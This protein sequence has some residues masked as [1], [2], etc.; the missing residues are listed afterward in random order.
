MNELQAY[1]S[2]YRNQPFLLPNPE[3]FLSRI[4][5]IP[6]DANVNIHD[7]YIEYTNGNIGSL[8]E[9]NFNSYLIQAIYFMAPRNLTHFIITDFD[10]WGFLS[11]NQ[12]DNNKNIV[13]IAGTW[14]KP[15]RINNDSNNIK[16]SLTTDKQL[17]LQ[18]RKFVQNIC[19]DTQRDNNNNN[20][21]DHWNPEV[22]QQMKK[23]S[24]YRSAH[25][26]F[27]SQFEA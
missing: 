16:K 20:N 18:C 15:D 21:N 17:V 6:F 14:L 3:N 23:M 8:G 12:M 7:S 4:P 24:S 19:K 10:H 5:L 2:L 13:N 26:R 11:V 1:Y 27:V 25:E 9:R 22:I